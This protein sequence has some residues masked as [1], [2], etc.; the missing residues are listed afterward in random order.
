MTRAATTHELVGSPICWDALCEDTGCGVCL[1]NTNGRL[2]YLNDIAASDA[3]RPADALI[4]EPYTSLLPEQTR[5]ERATL[6]KKTFESREPI[7]T[8]GMLRGTLHRT[9]YRRVEGAEPKVL[10]IDHPT[11]CGASE[12]RPILRMRDDDAGVLSKLTARE[13]DVLRLIGIGLSTADIAKSLH[14]SVKTI[15]WHRVSL[16]NKL[17]VAN[18][19]ELARIAIRGGLVPLEDT[20]IDIHEG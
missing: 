2:E 10:V 16:G 15:E 9:I 5:N 18:R 20:D 1:I 13:F 14:R 11:I 7:V 12:T 4:G 3:G 19:V 17:A 6:V 8:E